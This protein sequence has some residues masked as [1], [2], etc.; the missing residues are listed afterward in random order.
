MPTKSSLWFIIFGL[1]FLIAGGGFAWKTWQL[2]AIGVPVNAE[3]V[4]LVRHRGGKGGVTYAPVFRYRY[5]DQ[6]YTEESNHSSKPAAY[7]VGEQAVLTLDP[8]DPRDFIS[9]SFSD[10]WLLALILGLF[11]LL[12]GGI[13][14]GALLWAA[15]RRQQIIQLAQSG[16]RLS[17][18]VVSVERNRRYKVNRRSPWRVV[19]EARHPATGQLLTFTSDNLWSEPALKV[20]DTVEVH[21]DRRNPKLYHVVIVPIPTASF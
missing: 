8:T 4:E 10:R 2:L 6:V 18:Q 11:G 1:L 13:G 3:V 14:G 9:D 19:A 15:R 17:A 12:F 21:V 16:E 7:A 20:N 5:Q